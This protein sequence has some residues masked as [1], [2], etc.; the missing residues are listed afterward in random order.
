M[1]ISKCLYYAPAS[2]Q[3]TV[4]LVQEAFDVADIYRTPV[5]VMGDGML[6]QMMEP[7]EFTKK[8]K[9]RIFQKRLGQL[10]D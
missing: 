3:E 2:V 8:E 5:M 10:M 9:Q 1:E 4:D 7:V 6:G